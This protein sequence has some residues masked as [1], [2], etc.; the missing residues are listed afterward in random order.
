M[1]TVREI[2]ALIKDMPVGKGIIVDGV[3]VRKYAEHRPEGVQYTWWCQM[4]GGGV[5]FSYTPEAAARKIRA[6][7]RDLER[8]TKASIDA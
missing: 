3:D 7:V 4:N 8:D 2:V 5:Q 1:K 6:L